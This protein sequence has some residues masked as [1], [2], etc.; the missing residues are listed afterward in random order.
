MDRKGSN[1]GRQPLRC[2]VF[3]WVRRPLPWLVQIQRHYCQQYDVD[4]DEMNFHV[5]KHLGD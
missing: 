4:D 3:L 5:G 1:H 2:C